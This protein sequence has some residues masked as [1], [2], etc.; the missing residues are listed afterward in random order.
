MWFV[1]RDATSVPAQW[2]FKNKFTQG[3]MIG[4]RIVGCFCCL[5]F[6]KYYLRKVIFSDQV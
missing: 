3:R 2:Q 1:H 4:K 6:K 5:Y